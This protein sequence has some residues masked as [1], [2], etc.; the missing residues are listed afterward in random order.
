MTFTILKLSAYRHPLPVEIFLQESLQCPNAYW[1]TIITCN[2]TFFVQITYT[3]II[4]MLAYWDT[5]L[6]KS[7]DFFL[8]PICILLVV[9]LSTVAVCIAIYANKILFKL[10][11]YCTNLHNYRYP[12]ID[13]MYVSA[14]LLAMN[15]SEAR[16]FTI[17][18]M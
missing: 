14:R 15:C 13:K 5:D 12:H 7:V 3:V 4:F 10:N 2:S 6:N 9:C 8:N 11:E 18:G 16:S 17:R 1:Y